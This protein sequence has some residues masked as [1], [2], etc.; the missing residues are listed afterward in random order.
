MACHYLEDSVKVYK[1]VNRTLSADGRFIFSVK[2]PVFS[3]KGTQDWVYGT[4]GK[5]EYWPVDNYFREGEREAVFLGCGVR[6][7]HRTLETYIGGLLENGFRLDRIAE[8][9]PT[10]QAVRD[11]P[12]MENELR[13]PMMLILSATK[14]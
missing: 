6:K 14:L 3:A 2:H 4:E 10:Q 7:Y 9:Q 1:L 5:P 11:I 13:R 12:G 8:P